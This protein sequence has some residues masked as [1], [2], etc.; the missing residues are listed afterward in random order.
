MMTIICEVCFSV[1]NY[2]LTYIT[3]ALALSVSD[4]ATTNGTMTA[5][6][7]PPIRTVLVIPINTFPVRVFCVGTQP[8]ARLLEYC[9][10]R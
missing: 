2:F 1:E 7:I 6:S 5:A 8:A 9:K 4:V 3:S 10:K